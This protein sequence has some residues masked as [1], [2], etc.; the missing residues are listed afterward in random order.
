MTVMPD[1]LCSPASPLRQRLEGFHWG[2]LSHGPLEGGVEVDISAPPRVMPGLGIAES[3][4]Q[5][6]KRVQKCH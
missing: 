2:S 4:L 1:V 6:R 3:G 5:N